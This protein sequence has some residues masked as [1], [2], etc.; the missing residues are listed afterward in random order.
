MSAALEVLRPGLCTT[1]Q[2]LG[3][4]GYQK[5]GVPVSGALDEWALR[6]A[7]A[8]VGNPPGAAALEGTGVGPALRV[9]GGA[10]LAVAGAEFAL[11]LDGT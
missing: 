3:R 1:V 11:E 6:V 7:N 9:R 4:P 5:Y 2:D 10:L 8:L